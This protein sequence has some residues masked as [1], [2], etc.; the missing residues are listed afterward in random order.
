MR[1]SSAASMP[2]HW[3]ENASAT[4]WPRPARA[5]PPNA[6]PALP[7]T[8]RADGASTAASSIALARSTPNGFPRQRWMT[9]APSAWPSCAATARAS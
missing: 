3:R 9:T 7:P 6:A 1:T 4:R 2:A 8:P 5:R